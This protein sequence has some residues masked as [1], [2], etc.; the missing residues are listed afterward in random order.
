MRN[1]QL[2]S[3]KNGPAAKLSHKL[4]KIKLLS[5]A[6]ANNLAVIALNT[7]VGRTWRATGMSRDCR[8][9]QRQ[10]GERE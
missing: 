8:S 3:K 6:A 9:E 10:R 1:K 7:A 5:V 2:F 4:L